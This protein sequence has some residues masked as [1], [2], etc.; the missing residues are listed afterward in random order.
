LQG[1]LEKGFT[2]FYDF[3]NIAI[4]IKRTKGN[5]NFFK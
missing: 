2:L 5:I 4:I 3:G 1:V